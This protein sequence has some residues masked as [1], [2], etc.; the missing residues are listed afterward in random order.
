VRV[1]SCK[2]RGLFNK[3]ARRRGIVI[4]G[5]PDQDLT[6]RITPPL[7]ELEPPGGRRIQITR[8]GFND[9]EN[10]SRPHDQ[11]STV[12]NWSREGVRVIKSEPPNDDPTVDASS[13]LHLIAP[14]H[15]TINGIRRAPFL[16]TRAAAQPK[17]DG[18]GCR[19]AH[20]STPSAPKSKIDRC[21]ATRRTRRAQRRTS[22]RRCGTCRGVDGEAGHGNRRVC[23]DD[24]SQ[25]GSTLTQPT[26]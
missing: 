10:P 2:V 5:P 16:R 25:H 14:V 6:V 3:N 12:R 9:P 23:G 1:D 18:G 20:D 13:S 17:C 19:R 22:Y 4:S 8:P 21:Y 26:W 15:R 11:G 24:G 7:S